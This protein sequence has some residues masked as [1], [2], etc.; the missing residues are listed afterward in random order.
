[1]SK[2]VHWLIA[3]RINLKS[4]RLRV[5]FLI[6]LFPLSLILSN[7]NTQPSS[8]LSSH[9]STII[10]TTHPP[11]P[12]SDLQSPELSSHAAAAPSAFPQSLSSAFR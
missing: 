3:A 6:R 7:Q 11:S 12:L 10:T 2:V 5:L 8:P 4:H 1:M 9:S